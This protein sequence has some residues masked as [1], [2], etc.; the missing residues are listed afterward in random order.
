MITFE[1]EGT[2]S[3]VPFAQNEPCTLDLGLPYP[4]N[5]RI[6]CSTISSLR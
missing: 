4:N 6:T 2:R 5:V 3:K 1:V